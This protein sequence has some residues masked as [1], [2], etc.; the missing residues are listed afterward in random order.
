[1]ATHSRT[2]AWRIPWTEEPDE[3]QSTGS[4]SCTR[5]QQLRTRMY[6]IYNAVSVPLFSTVI[7]LYTCASVCV[8]SFRDSGFAGQIASVVLFNSAITV[9]R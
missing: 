4:Q 3:L 5:L 7:Q 2:L 6:L 9:G 8:Y 1:M